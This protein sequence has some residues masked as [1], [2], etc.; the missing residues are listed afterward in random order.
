M[1]IYSVDFK[2]K[3]ILILF[4]LENNLYSY[5]KYYAN[6]KILKS[7]DKDKK[8]LMTL[9]VNKRTHTHFRLKCILMNNFNFD[10]IPVTC[11]R[12]HIIIGNNTYRYTDGLTRSRDYLINL[13]ISNSS[14]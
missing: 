1:C 9:V 12:L 11:N 10:P 13:S 2:T 4:F 7:F 8:K 6:E 14:Y 3:L 5:Q